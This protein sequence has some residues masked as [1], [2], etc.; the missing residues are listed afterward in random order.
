MSFSALLF[1]HESLTIQCGTMLRA[2]GHGVVGVVTDDAA[3]TAWAAGE[4][5]PVIAPGA[6]LE[7]RIDASFD[8]IVSAANLRVIPEGVLARAAEGAV[9]F[10]DGPLPRY[11]GL[12]APVWAILNGETTHGIAWHL[13]AGGIDEGDL[14]ATRAL[15]ISPDETALSLNTKCYAAALDSFPEV[16]A[17]L[18]NGVPHR[19]PQDLSQRSYFGR[20]DRPANGGQIDFARPTAEILR[21][22]RALDH[23][24]HPNPLATAKLVVGEAL[25]HIGAATAAGGTGTPGE[26]LDVG[27]TSLTVTTADGAVLLTDLTG[28]AR[29][30]TGTVLRPLDD[31]TPLSHDARPLFRTWRPAT[32]HL[33]G[34]GGTIATVGTT[35]SAGACFAAMVR[36]MTH[37]DEGT[38]FALKMPAASPLV[39][40]WAPLRLTADTDIPAALAKAAPFPADLPHRLPGT[41]IAVPDVAFSTDG[42]V[43][44]ALVTL[45]VSE[46]VRLHGDPAR[47]GQAGLDLVAARLSNY[48]Q[49]GA[50]LPDAERDLTLTAWNDTDAPFPDTCIHT[51]F[52]AQAVRTPDAVALIFE[53][54]TLTYADL[55]AR[56]N[57]IAH[58][59]IATGAAPGT[60][61]GLHLRRSADLV[62][63]ALAILKAG[64]AYVPLDPAYPADRVAL[65]I[66]DSAC[67]IILTDDALAPRLP[68]SEATVLCV[69]DEMRGPRHQPRHPRRRVRPRL[70]H[71]HL[72]LDGPPQ[73]RDDRASQRR[74]L[75]HRHGRADRPLG[76]QGLARRH[77]ALVRHLRPRTLLDARARVHRR[78]GGRRGPGARLERCCGGGRHGIL[79][80]LLGQRR[81]LGAG[82]V[83]PPARGRQIRRHPRVLCR[84]DARAAFPRL[85]RPLSEPERHR[86]RGG[87]GDAQ[88]RRPRRVLRR[89]PAPPRPHRRGMGGDRQPDGGPRGP[90][91]RVRLAARRFRPAPREHAPRQQG[92]DARQH[93]DA[94]QTLG[95]RGRRLSAR[96]R[97]DARGRDAAAP[98]FEDAADLGHDGGQPRHL[99]RG[100]P[101]RGERADAPSGPDG[102]GGARTRSCSTTPPC[103]RRAT[104]RR[105]TR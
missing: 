47:I 45:D 38:D 18:A 75:L 53:A 15:A 13:I 102:R 29:P 22:V 39:S 91:H 27:D 98:D 2:A 49:T 86:R 77:V 74:Q 7:S 103:A 1:G 40:G 37:L 76:A 68:A 19:T 64:A 89:P 16:I 78:R 61:V 59:L 28:A 3:V 44:G 99:A 101:D 69:G 31:D 21:L 73:G 82:Q 54:E 80:V 33:P 105:R 17:A 60:F 63:G 48:I 104:T 11:A 50:I 96:G 4:G 94:A 92:R 14:I 95:R 79:A 56:A 10:H 20:N 62:A 12:N 24:A 93:R 32:L 67:G 70:S 8:W 42:P 100:G 6:G 51:A 72:R 71:L 97:H 30:A 41:T 90:C 83:R 46:G 58:R 52:E 55:N 81:H 25:V 36:L 43:P 9:N 88:H 84:L 26:V 5:V 66:G 57:R 87:G 23:G 85:R 65:Y 35:Q 34:T